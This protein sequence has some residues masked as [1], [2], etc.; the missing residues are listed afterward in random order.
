MRSRRMPTV[1]VSFFVGV[2]IIYLCM[3]FD[4]T[5]HLMLIMAMANHGGQV[6]SLLPRCLCGEGI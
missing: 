6:F 5:P 3:A 2:S 1:Q 4:E